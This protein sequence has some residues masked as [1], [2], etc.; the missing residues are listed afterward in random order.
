MVAAITVLCLL[1]ALRLPAME[2]A[3]VTTPDGDG[4]RGALEKARAA[5]KQ[6]GEEKA[7]AYLKAHQL[8]KNCQR[9]LRPFCLRSSQMMMRNADARYKY[10]ESREF[11]NIAA[12]E[13][14]IAAGNVA[15]GAPR[16]CGTVSCAEA[17]E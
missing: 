16:Q 8:Y 7:H 17:G 9:E 4:I 5:K 13:A 3:P 2:P 14:A 10:R 11:S 15:S 6:A 1:S 12:L